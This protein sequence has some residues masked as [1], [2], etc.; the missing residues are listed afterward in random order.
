MILVGKNVSGI[1]YENGKTGTDAYNLA[2][3]LKDNITSGT[4]NVNIP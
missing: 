4:L 1:W 3:K 2:K